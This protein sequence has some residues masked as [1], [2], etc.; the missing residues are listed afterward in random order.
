MGIGQ[1]LRD[2]SMDWIGIAPVGE[3]S[4]LRCCH[5]FWPPAGAQSR[6][7]WDRPALAESQLSRSCPTKSSTALTAPAFPVQKSKFFIALWRSP[8]TYC[9][10]YTPARI[11]SFCV[12]GPSSTRKISVARRCQRPPTSSSVTPD[13]IAWFSAGSDSM[14]PS[15]S[16]RSWTMRSS[17]QRHS[18]NIIVNGPSID[19]SFIFHI[20]LSIDNALIKDNCCI[21]RR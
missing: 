11:S 12:A 15:D 5:C 3:F 18:F 13:K 16:P 7:C 20:Q 10:E 4:A 9:A 1:N 2:P 17:S 21:F 14:A 8:A 6:R 19:L